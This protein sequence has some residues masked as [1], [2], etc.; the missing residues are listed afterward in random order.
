MKRVNI[1]GVGIS[2]TN[3][4]DAL[5]KIVGNFDKACGKYIC[6]ANVHTTVYAYEH[7]NYKKIQNESF[8]TLPD[9]KPLSIIGK[10]RGYKEMDRVTG[11]EFLEGILELSKETGW[12]HYFYGNTKDNIEILIK[13]LKEEYPYLDVVGYEPSVFR[14]LSENEEEDLIRR[15]NKA[16]ADFVW[17][18]LGAPKQEMFCARMSG[19]TKAIWVGVGGAFNVLPGI[20]PRAPHWM[21]VCCLEWFYRLMREP[22]RLFKRYLVTN[23]KFIYYTIINSKKRE[24]NEKNMH[25]NT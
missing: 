3:M 23:T 4:S 18:G 25:D 5:K 21:Q 13:Y 1:I 7:S 2:L 15:I 9:G 17:V 24:M 16:N 20:I 12:K 10:K 11:P 22:K 6:V 19:K 14:D 8:M